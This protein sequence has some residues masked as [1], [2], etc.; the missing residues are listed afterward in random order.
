MNWQ[1]VYTAIVTPF[2]DGEID[3]D[4]LKKLVEFQLENNVTGIVP[5]GTTGESPCLSDEEAFKLIENVVKWTDGKCKVIAGSGTNSTA[6]TIAKSKKVESLGVDGLLVVNPYYNKP[7]QEGLYQHFKA[8][9]DSVK[10]PIVLYNIKGR[11]GVNVETLT[12]MRLIKECPNIRIV[13]E[14]SGNLDQMKEVIKQSPDDF[15]VLSGDDGITLDLIKAGGDGVVSVASNI[16]PDKMVAL[17]NA[18]LKKDFD[19]AEKMNT[20]LKDFFEK[21]FI[22]TNPLP[23]KAA[24]AMKGMIEEEYRLPMCRMSSANRERWQAT[25]KN[26]KI[27]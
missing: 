21:E 12:L 18:A 5:C 16:I 22:E 9:A 4:A 8:V 17:V 20:E 11:T 23:I 6:K 2:K 27:L 7:T 3:W 19:E 15:T 1:G 24:L 25:L 10:I 13:K 26:M 14:A